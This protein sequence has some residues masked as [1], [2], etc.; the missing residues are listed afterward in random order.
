MGRTF[1]GFVACACWGALSLAACCA[2]VRAADNIVV[3]DFE[4]ADYGAW[5]VTGE[6][7]G[8]APAR[9]TLQGQ[10]NVSGF[11]GEQLVNSFHQGDGSTG[12]LESPPIKIERA[13]LSFLIGGGAFDGQTC[14]NLRIDGQTVRTATGGNTVAG[15]S[16]ELSLDYWD[17]REFSGKMATIEIVDNATGGWGHINVDQLM[18]TDDKPQVAQR[19]ALLEAR[20][21]I[22]A[23]Y[24]LLPI[25]TGARAVRVAVQIEGENVREFDAE[26][27]HG[28]KDPSFWAFLD[29]SSFQGKQAVVRM[30][31]VSE[32]TRDALRMA[33]SIPGDEQFYRE[34]L[35][36][37]FHFSQKIGWN[38]DPNGM[39]YHDG[40]WHLYFQHNPYGWNWGNM[41]W[42]HAVSEDLVHWKQLP[43][44]IYNKQHGDWAFSGGAVVDEHNTTGWQKGAEKVIVAAWT[45]TGRG[46]CL[47]YS[48]DGGLTFTEYE[49]NPVVKHQGRDPKIIWYEPGQHWVMAV[50]DEAKET[51]QS[52]AFYTSKDMKSWEL[53]SKISGYFEC[54]ELFELPVVGKPTTKL[55]VL[56]AADAKYALGEFDGKTFTPVHEGKH[57]VH[58]GEYYASQTFSDAPDARRIQIGWAR[59]AMPEMPFN[60]TFTFP[61]ELTLRETRDGV[62]LFA[63]PVREIERL[64]KVHHQSEKLKLVAGESVGVRVGSDLLHIR[65]TFRVGDADKIGLRLG[66][67]QVVYDVQGGSLQ[68]AP[69]QPEK[70]LIAI[71]LLVDRPMLEISGNEGRVYLTKPRSAHE[72][73]DEV[74]VYAEGGGAELESLDI[75]ELESIW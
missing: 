1:G 58:Y 43:I 2:A 51:G 59:I 22:K 32:A 65:A 46:E 70:G 71:E 26:L 24:L 45:S 63:E 36:P 5:R 74:Q 35:R 23:R 73:I 8:K 64:H 15:G 7:F 20:F 19:N 56:L 33:D 34:P 14:M 44:A 68:E 62:R 66:G 49:G 38:N 10:M 50:Y 21:D 13:Y 52:I 47:A 28:G 48:N 57:Q 30:R 27:A 37:Q 16:E 29:L 25:R 55:W 11:E 9:G 53:Q 17:V 72:P 75:Y 42:G 31:G 60:Q 41:H 67:E 4:Q 40:K 6:A 18:L 12:K 54:P 39:V 69:L 3:A 61:H